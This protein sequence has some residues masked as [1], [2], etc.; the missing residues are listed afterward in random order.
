MIETCQK[1]DVDKTYPVINIENIRITRTG[2]N[3]PP[4]TTTCG[5]KGLH[6]REKEE[7]PFTEEELPA[8]D[9]VLAKYK[10]E[11]KPNVQDNNNK[12]VDKYECEKEPAVPGM[13]P[14][15]ELPVDN[16][17]LTKYKYSHS[18]NVKKSQ[19]ETLDL[20][21]ML[22][23]MDENYNIPSQMRDEDKPTADLE[24]EGPNV[25]ENSYSIDEIY[26]EEDVANHEQTN[27][28]ANKKESRDLP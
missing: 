26:Q 4:G 24:S 18:R 2:T 8:D 20:A 10:Y 11:G 23:Y 16:G 17:A 15:E 3:K 27:G 14:K 21:K 7:D 9:K 13:P 1:G 6:T 12:M 5:V 28:V 19:R 22:D 25:R